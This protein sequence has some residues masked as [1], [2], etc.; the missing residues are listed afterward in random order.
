MIRSIRSGG[1][2]ED[3]AEGEDAGVVDHDVDLDPFAAG[4]IVQLRRSIEAC[5]VDGEGDDALSGLRRPFAD[6]TGRLLERLLPVARQQQVVA[7]CGQP[8]GIASAD[9]RAGP[10]DQRPGAARGDGPAAGGATVGFGAAH[11]RRLSSSTILRG[12]SG[13]CLQ[14]F[15][16]TEYIR[17]MQ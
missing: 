15:M 6:G 14:H 7:Q 13:Q 12:R 16:S 17:A 9:A 3:V 8:Q 10:G 5:Q 1:C 11:G 2:M 4:E